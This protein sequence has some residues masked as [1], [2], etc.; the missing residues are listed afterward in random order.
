MA[1]R[2]RPISDLRAG[3]HL[4]A[5]VGASLDGRPKGNKSSLT[6]SRLNV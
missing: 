4:T 1:K 2:D 5:Q 6:E 3:H